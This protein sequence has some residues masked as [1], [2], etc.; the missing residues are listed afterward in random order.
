MI[1]A[2]DKISS[3]LEIM[4]LIKE[5]KSIDLEKFW[6]NQY[7]FSIK[8]EYKYFDTFNYSDIQ[9]GFR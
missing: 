8:K 7:Q 2:A 3:K 9:N 1:L 6:S 5:K 4:K